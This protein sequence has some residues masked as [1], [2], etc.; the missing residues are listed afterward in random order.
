MALGI[1]VATVAQLAVAAFVPG[2][3]RFEGKA[4]VARLV[5]YPL[6]ML[7]VPAAWTWARRRGGG[8]GPLPWAAFAWIMLPFLVDVTG[9]CLDP[10]DSIV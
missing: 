4:F 9:N 3:E 5:A 7:A 10:Y 1:L 2:I 8:T 6:L